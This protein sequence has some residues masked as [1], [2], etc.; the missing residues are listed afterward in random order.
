ML[1]VWW[2]LVDVGTSDPRNTKESVTNSVTNA[3]CSLKAYMIDPFLG[4]ASK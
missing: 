4:V 1:I 2:C 3:A